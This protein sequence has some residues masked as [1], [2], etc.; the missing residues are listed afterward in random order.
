[1]A[2]RNKT[3][4]LLFTA[5]FPLSTH[6][7]PN[8]L[9][10]TELQ[11]APGIGYSTYSGV[12]ASGTV[13]VNVELSGPFQGNLTAKIN[14]NGKEKE[15]TWGSSVGVL[16]NFSTDLE[17]AFFAGVGMGYESEF[18]ATGDRDTLTLYTQAGK[19]F[20]VYDKPALF[21]K[22]SYSPYVR[23]DVAH[24][25]ATALLQILNFSMLF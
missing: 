13:G 14:S 21:T 23:V 3:L 11:F 24:G 18:L 7:S 10:V 17:R 15:A 4:F 20:L 2:F 6:A 1:M 5:L 9:G 8:P 16:Y 25:G 22:M 19:R 12:L